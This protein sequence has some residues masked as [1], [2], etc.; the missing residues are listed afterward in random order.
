MGFLE[1]QQLKLGDTFKQ[2]RRKVNRKRRAM[3]TQIKIGPQ[4]SIEVEYYLMLTKQK[5]ISKN[6]HT[7]T[8]ALLKTSTAYVCGQTG[9][10]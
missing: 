1:Q 7:Q 6:I 5:K 3:T 4:L 8:N 10:N 2:V 9:K